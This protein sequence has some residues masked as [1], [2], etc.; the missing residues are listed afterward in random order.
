MDYLENRYIFQKYKFS[1][2]LLPP[3]RIKDKQTFVC[4]IPK[5]SIRYNGEINEEKV[6]WFCCIKISSMA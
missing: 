2:F 4:D 1:L 5:L 3:L 6:K